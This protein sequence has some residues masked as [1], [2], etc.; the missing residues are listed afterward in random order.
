MIRHW[1]LAPDGRTP[2]PC[3]DA[4]EWGRWFEDA[5]RV[6]FQ[7]QVGPYQVSTV[8]L[9]LDHSFHE[10]GLPVLWETMVFGPQD[11]EMMTRYTS[12]DDA[13]AGHAMTLLT[14]MERY[15]G[16]SK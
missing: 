14:I 13:I 5:D 7:T 4:M 16:E 11:D 3:D 15:D 1:K 12:Y 9:G 10:G 6:V 2:I 8:F